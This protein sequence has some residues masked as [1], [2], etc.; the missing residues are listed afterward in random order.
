[1]GF[2]SGIL[3]GLIKELFAWLFG[4]AS[5]AIAMW[6]TKKRIEEKNESIK[7]QTEKAETEEERQA[8][9]RRAAEHLGRPDP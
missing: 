3:A 8:A 4:L 6:Q 9:L 7:E 1:M 5:K 2:I